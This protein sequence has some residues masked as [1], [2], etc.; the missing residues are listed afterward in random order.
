MPSQRAAGRATI[1]DVAR[2]ARV[3][4]AT[5]SRVL[6]ASA[7]VSDD[8]VK[9][10]LDAAANLEFRPNLLGRSLRAS[11][12][13]SLGVVLPTLT[14]PVFADCLQ[15]LEQA[16]R[17]GDHAVLLAT[18]GYD[19]A[20]EDGAIE[21]LLRQRVDG[22]VLTVADAARSRVLDKLDNERMPYVLVYNELG[23]RTRKPRPTVSVDNRAAHA[24]WSST[25]WPS[26]IAASPWS[27]AAFASP[28]GRACATGATSMRCGPRASRRCRRSSC[29]SWRS[30]RARCCRTRSAGA[31]A[32]PRCSVRTTSW[33]CW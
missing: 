28:I 2:R 30:M 8:V 17:A 6:N 23:R 15:G 25:C 5:V 9:A 4:A 14:H 31:N 29:R 26:V 22:L 11:R 3:S 32:R 24:R 1:L 18:T 20:Q 12:S 10:V 27:P 33:R 21:R 16:A 7:R 19:P 13:N